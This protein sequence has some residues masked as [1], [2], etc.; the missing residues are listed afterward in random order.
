M[1]TN[2]HTS[3]VIFGDFL[4]NNIYCFEKPLFKAFGFDGYSILEDGEKIERFNNSLEAFDRI[5]EIQKVNRLYLT[6]A[7]SYE[8]GAVL[9]NISVPH[10]KHL[11]L[12]L[13]TLY[14][15]D[16]FTQ[17]KLNKTDYIIN[18]NNLDGLFTGH[19]RDIYLDKI[20]K[21]I[22]LIKDGE[23]YQVNLSKDIICEC[24][25]N[26]L[27]LFS[28]IQS[29]HPSSLGCYFNIKSAS[30]SYGEI[31]SNS[32]ELF[33][34][35]KDNTIRTKPIKGTRKRSS[36]PIEDSSLLNDLMNSE[37]DL[38]ELSMIVD[39][40][41]NDLGRICKDDSIRVIRHAD[42]VKTSYVYHLESEITGE[43]NSNL[44]LLDILK[45][46]FPSG[47]ITGA[48]KIAA[49]KIIA[50][51]ENVQRGIYTGSLGMMYPNGDF[52]LNVAIRTAIL[53]DNKFYT[54]TGSGIVIDSVPLEEYNEIISKAKS[55][56]DGLS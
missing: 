2:N 34:E 31:I 46:S 17:C 26:G 15:F 48:P 42:L 37:K 13:Y 32:P 41:R 52:I 8:F 5:L 38:A 12:P 4:S 39:L 11:D 20:N 45:A 25:L 14:L 22:E 10:N 28:K 18:Q 47:S 36:D 19:S 16:N 49:Q 51:L 33:L 30:T 3:D 27:E 44:N 53:K 6:C 24:S 54:R 7:L 1:I 50:K 23:V 35:R 21:I 40:E 55:L 29:T 56:I 9:E 43:L